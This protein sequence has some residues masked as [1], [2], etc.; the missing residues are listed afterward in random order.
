MK[1]KVNNNKYFL[2]KLTI[3]A[4]IL[5]FVISLLTISSILNH[6]TTVKDNDTILTVNGEQVSLNEFLTV[7]SG[8][9]SNTY[10]YFSQKYGSTDSKNFWTTSFNG[11][12]PVNVLKQKTID[13]LKKLKIE[14]MLMKQYGITNDIS[15]SGFLKD[16][17]AENERRKIAV[18]ENHAIYGPMQYEEKIYY[19]N[20]Q[21]ERI[22]KLKQRLSGKK[23]F[24]SE[25]E[26]KI[27]YNDNKDEKYKNK[28]SIKIEK[29][30]L[31]II[32]V[33]EDVSMNEK[34]KPEM[35]ISQILKRIRGGEKFKIVVDDYKSKGVKEVE[36]EELVFDG[37]TLM[38]YAALYPEISSKVNDMN[39]N[40]ISDIISERNS[41]NIIKIIEK[42]SGVYKTYEEVKGQIK[43]ELI[44]KKY[45]R[46]INKLLDSANVKLREKILRKIPA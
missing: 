43:K 23:F 22:E 35:V 24:I 26:I 31:P 15:Y 44:D 11:E 3:L 37:S 45:E 36:F 41:L 1:I 14:Q 16:F 40:Q 8:L 21:T 17:K 7:L 20:L 25:E 28:D 9:R 34:G 46:M 39:T 30:A 10:S 12:V 2:K 33:Y 6:L 4:V 19:D 5:I 42:K 27:F 29:I 13:A 38:N 18:G 32:N